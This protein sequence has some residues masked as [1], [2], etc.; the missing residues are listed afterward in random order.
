MD[1]LK[2]LEELE[3][4]VFFSSDEDSGAVSVCVYIYVRVCVCA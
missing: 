3:D 2:V 4:E 1:D